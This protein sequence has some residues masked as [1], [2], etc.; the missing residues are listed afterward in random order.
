M[1]RLTLV[2]GTALPFLAAW[3]GIIAA[4]F[5]AVT[6]GS[7]TATWT[8]ATDQAEQY[9]FRWKHFAAT[10]WIPLPTVPGASGFMQV[11]FP[12]LPVTPTTD[13]W[14]CVDAR[15]VKPTLGPWLSE[16][17]DGPACNTVDV[18]VIPVPT[19][20]PPAPQPLPPPPMPP[21]PDLFTNVQ[22]ADGRL[23][24][25]YQVGACPRGVQQSTS[26]IK[27]GRRTITLTCRR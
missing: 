16:T 14:M 17:K 7:F 15:I 27:N 22:Q 9:E 12:A 13:R 26:A 5:S 25:E 24:V 10:D 2:L 3:L 11:T 23:S 4:G 19:P 1:R 18:G 20:P 6:N 21:Q 8:A